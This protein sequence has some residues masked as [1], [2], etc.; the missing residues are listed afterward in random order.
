VNRFIYLI[1]IPFVFLLITGCG[2]IKSPVTNQYT[3]TLPHAKS[4]HQRPLP[5]ALLISKP[6]AM[7]GYRTEQMLY[8]KKPFKREP[9]AKNAWSNPPADMLYPLLVEQF[10]DSHAFRAITS[11]PYADKAD[12][13]LDTQLIELHQNFLYKKSTLVFLAK[14]TLTRISDNRVLAS[15]LISENIPCK[16]NTPYGGVIAA[17]HAARIFVNK[18]LS[19]TIKQIKNDKDNQKA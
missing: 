19:F 9:F 7:S 17:N 18:T 11:S 13:R 10:Q 6:D 14:I 2:P 5:Y 4:H 1:T 16:S 3:L 8:L 15:Q 12:Y